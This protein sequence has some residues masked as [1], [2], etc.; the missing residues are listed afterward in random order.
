MR[1]LRRILA[2]AALA[3]GYGS[4]LIG[5]GAVLMPGKMPFLSSG[6]RIVGMIALGLVSWWA[7]CRFA[8]GSPRSVLN[9][10]SRSRD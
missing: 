6:S 3:A 7:G 9:D 8:N 2:I 5:I 1:L 10:H 4:I